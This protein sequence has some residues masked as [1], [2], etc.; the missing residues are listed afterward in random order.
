MKEKLPRPGAGKL[1]TLIAVSRGEPIVTSGEVVLSKEALLALT[2]H[3]DAP[4]CA[5]LE[6]APATILYSDGDYSYILRGRVIECVAPDRLVISTPSRPRVGERRE[7]IRADMTLSSRVEAAPT[8]M[9][10]RGA[11]EEWV[12]SF[13]S[14]PAVFRF[15]ETTVD[16]SGSGCRLTSPVLVKKG[17]FVALSLL[18]LEGAG[19]SRLLHVP[20]RVVRARPGRGEEGMMELALEFVSLSEA[21]RDLLNFLV[22]DARARE[23]G[24]SV[25]DLGG[26]E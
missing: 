11:L 2:V 22:F 5:R 26:D 13:P 1:V 14:D 4:L 23:L 6:D 15:R 24:M 20:A 8:G 25:V 9:T 7:Y 3:L 17:D 18:V 16:L 21:Q 10:G 12:D 19:G